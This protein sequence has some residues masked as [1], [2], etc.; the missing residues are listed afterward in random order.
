MW[1]LRDTANENWMQAQVPGTVMGA[2]L[3]ENRTP[4]PFWRENEQGA[5]ELFY[6]DYEY[7][8]T[9]TVPADLLGQKSIELV[10]L[11]ID[12]LS[13]IYLNGF[14]V[15]ATNNMHRTWRFSCGDRLL[16]GVN[17]LRIKLLSPLVYIEEYLPEYGK[18]ISFVPSGAIAG[19]QFIR[20][21]HSMFGWDW[22]L[23]IPDAGIWRDIF[24][25]GF[26]DA[27]ISDV[28]ILQAHEPSLVILT[29]ITTLDILMPLSYGVE[30]CIMDPG[31]V[32]V[33]SKKDLVVPAGSGVPCGGGT[34]SDTRRIEITDPQLWWPNDYG[35][36]PLYQV[37]VRLSHDGELIQ[38]KSLTIGL[39][40]LTV[41]QERDVWGSEFAVTVNGVRIFA[42]GAN[43]IPEDTVYEH[44]TPGKIEYLIDSSAK[45]HFNCLRVWG[46]GY[47]PSDLFYDLCDRYG[48]I[49]WQ[50]LMYA[51]NVYEITPAFEESI[52]EETKDNVRRLRHH[53]SLG[54][55][56]GNNEIESGWHHWPEIMNH[57]KELKNDYIRQFEEILPRV[58]GENDRQTF[59]WRSSPSS[60]GFFDEPDDENRGDTHYWD[61][62]HGLKPF[63]EFRKH[64]FRFCSEFGFQSFP[65]MK[66]INT[67]TIP[68]DRNIF[69]KVME[70]HQKNGT[71]N[72]K[73]LHY[74]SEQFLY[75]KDFESILYVSQI[76]Q[77]VA[78]KSGVEH[79]RRNRGRCMGSLYWQLND[80]APV[81]SW[82]SIDYFGRWKALQY[83]ARKF[84]APL[85]ASFER[86]D[87]VFS[88]YI[89]NESLGFRKLHLTVAL[90]SFAFC[91][92]DE[93]SFD[94]KM[95]PHC[96][97]KV[98]SR[99][100]RELAAGQKDSCF[101]SYTLTGES[102][103]A[104][105][106]T[107]L[108]V[109]DK[110]ACLPVPVITAQI[111]QNE[112]GFE[113]Q[114]LTDCFARFVELDF[115]DFDAVFSDNFFDITS[116]ES[117]CVK[118]ESI[119]SRNNIPVTVQSLQMNLRIRQLTDTY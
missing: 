10:C 83:M 62:W 50:D 16:P 108:F 64:Y 93:I 11:G 20:K 75:P 12:T 91:V 110:H 96:A 56:C 88:L 55:W 79:W 107:V 78:M 40:T 70:S 114:M 2:L 100:Y 119:R 115:D 46:G 47:Y 84:Y 15:A 52:I 113:I 63:S 31:G 67:F 59:Y 14:F 9:F 23:Q 19:N 72:A 111:R 106:D 1:R 8:R 18:N 109:P 7:E 27:R 102:G 97:Q 30:V 26:S 86:E 45:S 94:T 95:E 54:L 117:F 116:P 36:H 104:V 38:E 25:E 77:G 28:E 87:D 99:D 41:S 32:S 101:L 44:I 81:A 57:S 29:V 33:Y 69:S 61:V 103:E 5:K 74:I 6:K 34:A 98:F 24:L 105:T 112:N 118:I 60:G 92:L 53:A 4:D 39:R 21:A 37:I 80:N 13:E 22:G 65:C 48:I 42:R 73:I 82:S 89:S 51:C 85:A 66:T 90:K 71:A 3:R 58:T 68:K 35:S 49:V 43:Y 76:L 17:N